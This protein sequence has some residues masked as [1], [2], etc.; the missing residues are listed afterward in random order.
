MMLM[1]SHAK[2]EAGQVLSK[3]SLRCLLR[4]MRTSHHCPRL[5]NRRSTP[6]DQ[7]GTNGMVDLP[8]PLPLL[9]PEL[10]RNRRFEAGRLAELGAWAVSTR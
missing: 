6:A 10:T 8:L 2:D 3:I 7:A 4:R 5:L 1:A 9:L